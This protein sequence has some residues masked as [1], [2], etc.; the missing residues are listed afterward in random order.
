MQPTPV[1]QIPHAEPVRTR[2]GS[3]RDDA[4]KEQQWINHQ[5]VPFSWLALFGC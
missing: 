3:R 2:A 1:N 4:D 5:A